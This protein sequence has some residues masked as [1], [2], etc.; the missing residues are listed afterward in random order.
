MGS[1]WS[2]S[3]TLE[4]QRLGQGIRGITRVREAGWS[5]E[6][7]VC[8]VPDAD[9]LSEAGAYQHP[10]TY[11]ACSGTTVHIVGASED[12]LRPSDVNRLTGRDADRIVVLTSCD[13]SLGDDEAGY[14]KSYIASRVGLKHRS[15]SRG[16]TL[17][18]SSTRLKA[19]AEYVERASFIMSF[20][21][22]DLD[23]GS[24][25]DS[26]PS[27]VASE[28]RPEH[29]AR[30]SKPV[31]AQYLRDHGIHIGTAVNIATL[32]R[33]GAWFWINPRA[34]MLSQDWYVILNDNWNFE[35]IALRIPPNTLKIREEWEKGRGVF[36]RRDRKELLDLHIDPVTLRD[37][38]SGTDFS[39]FVIGRVSY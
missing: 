4:L 14:V 35:L 13:G 16:T 31:A 3:K 1:E 32:S 27:P 20:M 7:Y 2:M 33:D 8:A 5:G 37:T 24:Q 6:L 36:L 23:A 26:L 34:T 38:R 21:G 39:A 17:G 10:G 18:I 28:I 22:I 12:L 25:A 30:L 29:G 9:R 15:A 11:V 19:L